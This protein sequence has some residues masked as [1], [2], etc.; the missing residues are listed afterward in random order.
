M[1][2][3][4]KQA[5][6]GAI[7]DRLA[8]ATKAMKATKADRYSLLNDSRDGWSLVGTLAHAAKENDIVGGATIDNALHSMRQGISNADTYLGAAVRG[9]KSPGFFNKAFTDS[10]DNY[11]HA[12]GNM[13]RKVDHPSISAPI[14]KLAPMVT[15]MWALDAGMKSMDSIRGKSE[16]SNLGGGTLNG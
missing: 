6:I 1:N 5:F 3:L 4:E 7:K 10:G 14:K 11:V 8:Y 2:Q 16:E 15:G 9:E 13:Y 12:G